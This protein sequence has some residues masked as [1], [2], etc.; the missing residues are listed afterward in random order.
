MKFNLIYFMIVGFLLFKSFQ[1]NAQSKEVEIA[2]LFNGTQGCIVISKFDNSEIYY[3]NKDQCQQRFSPC[4]T[5]KIPNSLI[6][7]QTGVASG[8]DFV[9][10]WDSIRNP[11][12]DWMDEAEPFKYWCKDQ[13]MESALKYSVVWYYQEI[14]RRIGEQRMEQAINDLKYGN[15]DISS[16]LDRFWL[17]GSMQISAIEQI[18]FLRRF[19]NEKLSG[20]SRE[21][22][23]AVKEI[24][25]YE[26]TDDYKLYGKT[27]GGKCW[28][29]QVV[30]WYVGFV[31][32]PRGPYVF[33]MNMLA[34][35][36]KQFSNNRRQEVV[37]QIFKVLGYI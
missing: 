6:A 3:F 33:A 15:Q 5:F 14:A 37:K 10:Q 36:F 11:H 25:L 20:F 27:G 30:G 7:L 35:D 34:K 28:P 12:E 16:A 8:T 21:N 19:Y 17:C 22:I 4:S 23:D 9:I 1:I 2:R 18:A 26:K 31:E 29:D 32:T 13:T 24:M